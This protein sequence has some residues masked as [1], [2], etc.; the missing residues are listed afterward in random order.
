MKWQKFLPFEKEFNLMSKET[1]ETSEQETSIAEGELDM[2]KK[3][4][5]VNAVTDNPVVT[6]GEG[7]VAPTMVET[8]SEAEVGTPA[9][10][11][12]V[13]RIEENSVRGPK[14]LHGSNT[15]PGA[16]EAAECL[17]GDLFDQ[18]KSLFNKT[19][20]NHESDC[21]I[22]YCANRYCCFKN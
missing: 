18:I 12:K 9:V 7:Q 6:L 3:S 5:P 16:A 8:S 17:E 15:Q 2:K 11:L 20:G 10:T 1:V 13:E 21:G 22:K 19:H 14:V 4:I